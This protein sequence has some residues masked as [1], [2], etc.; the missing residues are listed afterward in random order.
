VGWPR[1]HPRELIVWLA[2]AAYL[3]ALVTGCRLIVRL[4]D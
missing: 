1:F 2:I 4:L 3:G